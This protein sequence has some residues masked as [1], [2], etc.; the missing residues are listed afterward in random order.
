MQIPAGR[1]AFLVG[2]ELS[3]KRELYFPVCIALLGLVTVAGGLADS[4]QIIHAEGLELT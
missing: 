2:N 3:S 4:G 1:A